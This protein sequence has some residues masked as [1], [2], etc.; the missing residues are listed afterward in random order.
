MSG[1]D[2]VVEGSEVRVRMRVTYMSRLPECAEAAEEAFPVL[3]PV[4]TVS[5][6]S[7]VIFSVFTVYLGI[8]GSKSCD[9]LTVN[10]I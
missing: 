10:L 7:A 2:R 9:V 6:C 3:P 8:A 1:R 5:P 4:L